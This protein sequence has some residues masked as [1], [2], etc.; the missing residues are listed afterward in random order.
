MREL[1]THQSMPTLDSYGIPAAGVATAVLLPRPSTVELA[2][3]PPAVHLWPDLAFQL[4]E[5]PD[6]G[7]IGSE[8]RLDL[9]GQTSERQ[10]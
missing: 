2:A 7:A 3:S 5:A 6:P 10:A 4:H 1:A 9:D 8:V